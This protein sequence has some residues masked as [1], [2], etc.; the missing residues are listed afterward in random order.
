MAPPAL[1]RR[2]NAVPPVLALFPRPRRNGAPWTPV[3]ALHLQVAVLPG[4]AAVPGA[5]DRWRRVDRFSHPDRSHSIPMSPRARP[6]RPA[7]A[8]RRRHPPRDPTAAAPSPLDRSLARWQADIGELAAGASTLTD[9]TQLGG[10]LVDLTQAHPSGIA[11]LY[12]ARPGSPSLVREFSSLV[13]ARRT[14]RT[15]LQRAEEVLPALRHRADLPGDRDRALGGPGGRRRPRARSPPR[16]RPPGAP[17]PAARGVGPETG[18]RAAA[19]NRGS[20]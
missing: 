12:A 19:P 2:R 8:P 16:P 7:T 1:P 10:A 15:V 5:A 14:A 11:Q 13:V 17:P 9:I 6:N 3:R 20:R 18:L 4:V